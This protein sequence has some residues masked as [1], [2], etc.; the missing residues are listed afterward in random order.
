LKPAAKRKACAIACAHRL[1][2][3]QHIAR[4]GCCK[5]SSASGGAVA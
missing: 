2:R 4:A 3:M 1:L 5:R